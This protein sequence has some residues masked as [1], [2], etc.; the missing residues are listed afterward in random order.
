MQ[1]RR[2]AEERKKHTYTMDLQ[3]MKKA[4][5]RSKTVRRMHLRQKQQE[6]RVRKS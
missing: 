3:K 1:S 2:W 4:F 6:S 5:H